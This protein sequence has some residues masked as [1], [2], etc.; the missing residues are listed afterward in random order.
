MSRGFSKSTQPL[1]LSFAQLK[2]GHY[3]EKGKSHY[4]S[5]AA[6]ASPADASSEMADQGK[7]RTASASGLEFADGGDP[8]KYIRT[9]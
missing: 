8:F 3:A 4:F 6:P 5:M 9:G 1:P 7:Y 2:M